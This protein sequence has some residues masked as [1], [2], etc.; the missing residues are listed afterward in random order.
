MLL[1]S[2]KV[3][4]TK[5]SLIPLIITF[6]IPLVLTT[7][8][9][10]L[11]NAVDIA[12]LGNMAD[13]TAV[14][15]VGATNTIVGLLIDT[16]VGISSGAKIVFSRLFGKRDEHEIKR[17]VDTS[18]LV[19]IGFGIIIALAG[20]L[21]APGFLELTDCPEECLKGA[22]LYIRI[23][24]MSAPA[25]LIYNYGAAVLTSS[26]D[27]RRPLY[28]AMISGLLNVVLNV[29]LCLI[30]TEKVA[31]VAIATA[32]SQVLAATLTVLRLRKLEGNARLCIRKMRFD[33]HAFTQL[34]RFG[35]PLALQTLV[36]PLANIQIA[37]GINSYGVACVAGNSAANTMHQITA[38][39]RMAFGTAI[40]TFMG[41]NLG[42][43]RPERVRASFFH[44]VW[45]CIALC[46]P[47]SLLE[48]F[49]GPVW[50]PIFLGQ[51]AVATSYAMIRVAIMNAFVIFL[52][53]NT[54]LGHAIQA[55]GYPVF[56]TVNAVAWVLGFR[57][58]WMSVIYPMYTSYASLIY[59]FGVSYV[60][61]FICNVVIFAVLYIRYRKG[62]YKR[63]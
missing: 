4:A 57:F 13:T 46:M 25:I 10:R 49:L 20:F 5:G 12:V 55:L 16:F 21:F 43:E 59:C 17:T 26:G 58:F 24:V 62:K 28:Y 15:A 48:W 30:L 37:A 31:A 41:Q 50:L 3:D 53:L 39:F 38:S 9:Q 22:I 45:M 33:L 11:F 36:Y 60:F 61:T 40:A 63:I 23:Y 8:I 35:V 44:C 27:S 47:L 29:L 42:A 14:A 2:K 32:M 6:V 1:G 52:I 54:L 18:M 19:A 56:S 51:D 34:M 7:L